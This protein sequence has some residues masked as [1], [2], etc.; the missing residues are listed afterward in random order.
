MFVADLG[1][2]SIVCFSLDSADGKMK[3]VG[4]LA[5]PRGSGPRSLVFQRTAH[6]TLGHFGVVSLEMTAQIL[7]VRRRPH[8]GCLEALNS[9]ISILPDDWPEADNELT[10]FN[11]GRWASDVV[12]SSNGKYIFAAARLHNSIAVFEFNEQQMQLQFLR[13][14]PTGGKTPRCLTVSPCGCFLLIAHQHSH[15]IS[16]FQI[17]EANGALIFVDKLEAPLAACIKIS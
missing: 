9:P 11:K 1:T 2:D 13:R 15:D 3:Q 5:A 17:D 14:V 10:K 12:W 4:K 8:D 6:K 7:L 16:S